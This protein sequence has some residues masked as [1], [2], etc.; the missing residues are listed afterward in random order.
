MTGLHLLSEYLTFFLNFVDSPSDCIDGLARGA[1]FDL[2]KPIGPAPLTSVNQ[3]IEGL[4]EYKHV[5][6]VMFERVLLCLPTLKHH[7]K[8]TASVFPHNLYHDAKLLSQVPESA[9]VH[10]EVSGRMTRRFLFIQSL[11]HTLHS[12]PCPLSSSGNVMQK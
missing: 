9:R 10:L 6:G 8:H 12:R 5:F 2:V 7:L 11:L 4:I 3:P 1:E